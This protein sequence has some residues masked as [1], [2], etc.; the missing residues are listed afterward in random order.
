MLTF[1]N[2]AIFGPI[3]PI[4]L[5]LAGLFLFIKLS[6][7]PFK[8]P[9]KLLKAFVGKNSKTSFRSA[10]LSL[11]GTLGVGNI[12]GVAAAIG[13]GGAGTV[14]WMWVFALFAMVIKYAEVV[15]STRYQKYGNGGAALYMR[16]GLK[17]PIFGVL[18]SLLIIITSIFMGN[19]VQS[20]AAAESISGCFGV[21]KLLVGIAFS[22]IT[23]IMI[24]GGRNRIESV[25]AYIIPLL[26]LGYI[27]ISLAIIITAYKDIPIILSQIIGDAFD[28]RACAGGAFGFL[29]SKCVRLGASRGMLSNEAGCGTVSYA[30]EA[31]SDAAKQGVWGIFEVFADTILLCTLTAFVVLLTP[32]SQKGS[33]GM[34][35]ALDAYGHYGSWIGDFIGISSAIYALASVVCWSYYGVSALKYLGGKR[36][37]RRLYLLFY[38]A[39][40]ILGSV[41]APS[42]IWEISDLSVSV[43]AIFNTAC[44]L[45]LYKE[46]K[47]STDEYF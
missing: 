25:S 21:P 14:F 44:V 42:L 35:I 33:N 6:F 5:C 38:S 4:V 16:Y 41:F 8:N 46:I 37:S 22:I 15:L 10:C 34:R 11:S 7:K 40:G 1:I 17:K 19:T 45:L 47:E 43:I 39:A 32:I 27:L 9:K 13:I 26:S 31:S 24:S 20:S 2:S 30:H 12:A 23:L 36:I 18:F 3:L 28:I 29:F